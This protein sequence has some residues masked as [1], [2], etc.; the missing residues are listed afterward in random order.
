MNTQSRHASTLCAL[1]APVLGA[2]CIATAHAAPLTPHHTPID[3]PV[4]HGRATENSVDFHIE[5]LRPNERG[6][7]VI[8]TSIRPVGLNGL[9]VEPL[10]RRFF[11]ADAEGRARLSFVSPRPGD[12][13]YAQVLGGGITSVRVTGIAQVPGMSLVQ[14]GS[15]LVTEIQRAPGQVADV[16][17][18]WFEVH[19]TTPA[20]IDMEGWTLADFGGEQHVIQTGGQGLVIPVGS[21]IVLGTN[22]DPTS[23]GGIAVDYGYSGI[24]LDD[25]GDEIQLI[26]TNGLVVDSVGWN[27]SG[28]WPASVTG[29]AL[30]LDTAAI[31]AL[32][33]DL[34]SNWCLASTPQNLSLPN[35]D[36]GTPGAPNPGC[37]CTTQ[38]DLPDGT[39]ADTNC[40]GLD[41]TIS[42]AIFVATSGND[43]AAGTPADP[44]RTVQAAINRASTDFSKDHVYVSN[45]SYAGTVQL[46]N[47]VSVWGGYSQANGWARSSANVTTIT[48]GVVSGEGMVGIRAVALA[49][50]ITVGDLRV[51]TPNAT[52]NGTH[53]FGVKTHQVSNLRLE[54]VVITAGSGSAGVAGSTG[55]GTSGAHAGGNGGAGGAAFLGGSDGQDGSGPSGGN[56]GSGGGTN[57]NGGGGQHGSGGSSGAHGSPGANLLSVNS[58]G[59]WT[60]SSI[61]SAGSYGDWGSAGGGGGGGGGGLFFGN[62][63]GN[64]GRGGN[65]GSSG[66]GGGSGTGGGSSFALAASQ[67]TVL[68]TACTLQS[69]SGG[70]GGA[71][72]T[73]RAGVAGSAGVNGQNNGSGGI[74]GRGGNGGAGGS[75]GYGAGAGGGHTHA[76]VIGPGATVT[77]QSATLSVGTPGAGGFSPTW[78]D[79]LGGDNDL[80]RQ[81]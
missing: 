8:G 75:G 80:I 81:L 31:D 11:R 6:M 30:T 37:A 3:E 78:N 29:R 69:G 19:N 58:S 76:V 72:G 55:T 77:L 63:G 51:V 7:L 48:G 38:V 2:L 45:G 5:G 46:A 62:P 66:Q 53:N 15:V 70:A 10:Q 52:G 64:G 16:L 32:A 28:A 61:G 47:G 73:P 74:G 56:G 71:A 22:M 12:V 35:S 9:Q 23:N 49:L 13:L 79:G 43:A 44:L 36:R 59:V 50:P 14:V 68:A 18:E 39:F 17:G 33:N 67:S 20:P 26:A 4:V 57:S 41:G 42:R 34:G 25:L 27:N 24:T 21:Y 40:D 60:S 1:F 54:R 65:G